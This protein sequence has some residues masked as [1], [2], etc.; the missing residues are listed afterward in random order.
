ML[1]FLTLLY[2]C[3]LFMFGHSNKYT[4]SKQTKLISCNSGTLGHLVNSAAVTKCHISAPD[5]H[6]KFLSHNWKFHIQDKRS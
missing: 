3:L 6:T 1:I 4:T 2:Y 5:C